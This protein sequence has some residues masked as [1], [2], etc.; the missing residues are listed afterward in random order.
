MNY[1]QQWISKPEDSLA[2]IETDIQGSLGSLPLRVAL[3]NPEYVEQLKAQL[4]A[5][6]QIR[7]S[8]DQKS[9]LWERPFRTAS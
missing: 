6:W 2:F 7:I 1:L 3:T 4:D 9:H 5:L 8:R